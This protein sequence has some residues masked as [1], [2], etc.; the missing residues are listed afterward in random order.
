MSNQRDVLWLAF[1]LLIHII[2]MYIYFILLFYLILF[3]N[4][5]NNIVGL[6]FIS[7]FFFF[8]YSFKR[9][10]FLKYKYIFNIFLLIINHIFNHVSNQR[11]LS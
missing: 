5:I 1:I 9:S 10:K 3:N 6:I 11:G 8:L 2:L 7:P 4:I